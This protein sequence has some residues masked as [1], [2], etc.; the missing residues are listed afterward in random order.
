MRTLILAL[1]LLGFAPQDKAPRKLEWKL[2][3]GHMAE[4]AYL[5]RAG[6]PLGDQKLLV[7]ASEL[8][9]SGNRFAIDTYEKIPLALV[10]QL[11]PEPIKG[12]MGW[13]HQ[14]NFFMDALDALGG[15][16]ALGAGSI[17]PACAKGRYLVKIQKK[18]DDEIAV[19]DGAFSIVEVRRDMVNNQ[20]KTILTKVE[21]GTL[22]TSVQFNLSKGLIQKAVWQYKIRA[23]DREGG[24]MVDKRSETQ[25]MIELKEDVE[26]DAAK[27]QPALDASVTR[28]VEWLKKQQKNGAWSAARPGPNAAL[29][30]LYQ[31]SIVVRALIAA[32]V[33]PD[34]PVI[35]AASKTLRTPPPQENFLLC[36][37]ILALAAKSPAKEEAD[38]LKRFAEELVKRRDPRTF[39]WP[40]V[41]GRGDIPGSFLT[42]L[43]LEA[44][45]AVPDA[46]I[47][48]EVLR[49]GLDFFTGNWV[50]DDGRVDLELE[51]EKDA[52]TIALDPAKD[53]NTVPVTWPALVGR[54]ANA[55]GAAR[56]GS[57]F[58]VVA[59]L[60]VL[61]TV[62]ERVK[63][64][65]RAAKSLELPIKRGFANLQLHWTLRSVPPIEAFWCTQRME[66]LSLL[67][68]TLARAKIEKIGGADWRLEGATL[69]MREQGDDGSWFAGTDLAVAKT[70]HALLFLAGAKR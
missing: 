36:Q 50:E 70:A 48:D 44:L 53:K 21:L 32:G 35:A 10:F 1:I 4:Y 58:S 39:G 11:P 17:R 46:K 56:K 33:K 41:S 55:V 22:A 43:A 14:V 31:T 47:P 65:D 63:L 60:R 61:L 54:Q 15:F 45:A 42:A 38:D 2:P 8:T 28:A 69:L 9:P 18:G 5:D 34:D 30:A 13:E 64:D 62:P 57:F 23:Q 16:D 7:F 12:G 52:S 49:T 6:K 24:R 68:P 59:A 3:A 29:D 66:Y 27:V 26:L 37:Q 67:G 19:I 20:L 25:S 51:L 40:G